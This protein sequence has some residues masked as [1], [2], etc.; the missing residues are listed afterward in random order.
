[1]DVSKDGVKD[2]AG[3]VGKKSGGGDTRTDAP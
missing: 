2:V 3:D 1:M